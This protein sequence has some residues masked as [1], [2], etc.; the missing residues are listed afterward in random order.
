[1]MSH[2]RK[3]LTA[4]ILVLASAAAGHV[5]AQVNV[6]I[7]VGPPAPVHEQ[8]P[9]LPA[10]STWAPGYWAWQD[11]RHIWVHGRAMREHPGYR[12]VP[13]N[14]VQR[15]NAYYRQPGEWAR[16]VDHRPAPR[17]VGNPGLHRGH[18]KHDKGHGYDKKS[19]KHKD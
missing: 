6:T 17:A 14:W 5:A 15:G 18:D 19:R 2:H 4:A 13:D 12:W 8:V 10:G 11:G 16:D 9:T 3:F 7:Q 1:M